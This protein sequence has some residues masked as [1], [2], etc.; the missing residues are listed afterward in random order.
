KTATLKQS[1]VEE[2]KIAKLWYEH[3]TG[4]DDDDDYLGIAEDVLQFNSTAELISQAASFIGDIV[5]YVDPRFVEDKDIEEIKKSESDPTVRRAL[6]WARRGQGKFRADL[7]DLW[8]GCAVLKFKIPSLPEVLRAS[9]IKPW[10]KCKG[11]KGKEEK[12]DPNNGL[13]LSATL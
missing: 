1:K 4:V 7:F 3:Y 5:E 2:V 6:I 12:L 10:R 9:H 13:L 8:G 11:E